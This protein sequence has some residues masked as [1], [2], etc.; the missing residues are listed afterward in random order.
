LDFPVHYRPPVEG[1]SDPVVNQRNTAVLSCSTPLSCKGEEPPYHFQRFIH[2]PEEFLGGFV[3]M[4]CMVSKSGHRKMAS[5]L[6]MKFR[7]SMKWNSRSPRSFLLLGDL[8][9][10]P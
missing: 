10:P 4:L 7:I 8:P 3:Y 5:P 6:R 2:P 9:E 1:G